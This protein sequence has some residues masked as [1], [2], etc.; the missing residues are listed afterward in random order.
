MTRTRM[1][2]HGK[3]CRRVNNTM[4]LTIRP[5][6]RV[7]DAETVAIRLARYCG[8]LDTSYRNAMSIFRNAKLTQKKSIEILSDIWYM[9]NHEESSDENYLHNFNEEDPAH[10]AALDFTMMLFPKFAEEE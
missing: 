2:A 1:G 4:M 10:Q 9:A 5:R 3:I 8:S 6:P 7:L